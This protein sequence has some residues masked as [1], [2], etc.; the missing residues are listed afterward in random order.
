MMKKL[1][2]PTWESVDAHSLADYI[3]RIG[4]K[5]ELRLGTIGG[6]GGK[7]HVL[8]CYIY[9]DENFPGEE[10]FIEC[11]SLCVYSNRGGKPI[12]PFEGNAGKK[13]ENATCKIC[14]ERFNAC[15]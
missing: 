9:T 15:K 13:L 10:I 7:I 12:I 14:I 11:H 6:Y 2:K 1:V 3:D 4:A 5:H 8:G